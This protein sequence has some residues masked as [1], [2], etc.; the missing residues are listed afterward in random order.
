MGGDAVEAVAKPVSVLEDSPLSNARRGSSLNI[1]GRVKCDA[2]VMPMLGSPRTDD[3]ST[4]GQVGP[5]PSVTHLIRTSYNSNRA[6]SVEMN[7][8]LLRKRFFPQKHSIL[9]FNN[10]DVHHRRERFHN[11]EAFWCN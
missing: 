11:H 7:R 9:Y 6:T 10:Y 1:N 3:V 2:S 8:Q 5:I 4:D